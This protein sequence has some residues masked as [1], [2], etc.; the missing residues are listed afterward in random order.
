MRTNFTLLVAIVMALTALAAWGWHYNY[1]WLFAIWVPLAA[2]G[3]YDMAQTRH[4]IARNFPVLG[5]LRYVAEWMRPKVYQYF[6][7]SDTDGRPFSRLNRNIIYQRAKKVTD[8]TP[9]GTQLD[10][11]EEG[12]A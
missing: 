9:F 5:R 10:V 6:V 1:T 11:Y 3:F 4:A 2:L 12:Y 7:E 8:S